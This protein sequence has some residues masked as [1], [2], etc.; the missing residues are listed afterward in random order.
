MHGAEDEVA[1]FGGGQRQRD[2]LQIAHFAD[3]NDVGILAQSAS[4]RGAEG[5][6]VWADLALVDQALLGAVHELDWILDG[7]DVT[8]EV[9]VD[10]VDH[11]GQGGGLTGAGRSGDQDQALLLVADIAQNL[12]E[13]RGPPSS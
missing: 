12:A 8:L 3:Q 13:D 1:G 5:H 2:G 10:V 11:R 4:Q 7:E 6:R 9:V